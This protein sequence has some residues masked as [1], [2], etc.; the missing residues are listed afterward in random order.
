MSKSIVVVVDVVVMDNGAEEWM[1][2]KEQWDVSESVTP[3]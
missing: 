3:H 1:A 2:K